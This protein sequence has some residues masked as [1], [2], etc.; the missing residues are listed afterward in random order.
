MVSERKGL[1]FKHAR[2][3]LKREKKLC[4]LHQIHVKGLKQPG[5]KIR[6][7]VAQTLQPIF[8]KIYAL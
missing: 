7:Y 1:E 6:M 8:F 2:L 4:D 3:V 5:K